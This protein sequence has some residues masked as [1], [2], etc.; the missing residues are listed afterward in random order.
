MTK[1]VIEKEDQQLLHDFIS[2]VESGVI[3]FMQIVLNNP[4]AQQIVGQQG[5]AE[6]LRDAAKNLNANVDD[7]VPDKQTMSIMEQQQQMIQQLQMQMQ[8]HM[9]DME[10]A[11]IQMSQQGA[12][13]RDFDI[14]VR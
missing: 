5:A 9:A 6:L 2:K 13:M 4:M 1:Y 3:E 14:R 12:L 8:Q 7:I 11:G 10:A